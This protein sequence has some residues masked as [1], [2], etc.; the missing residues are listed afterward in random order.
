[1]IARALYRRPAI[2]LLD[3]AT[4]HLNA[5]YES[6]VNASIQDMKITQVIIAHRPST[7]AAADR[8]MAID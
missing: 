1:M 8:R 2:L 3:E 4:S 5:E 7:I 6:R